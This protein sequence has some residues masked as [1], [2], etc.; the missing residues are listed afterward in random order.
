[1]ARAR[2]ARA[3]YACTVYSYEPSLAPPLP[4]LVDCQK[5]LAALGAKY[6]AAL[7]VGEPLSPRGGRA[8]AELEALQPDVPRR[9]RLVGPHAAS[10]AAARL[11]LRE[12]AAARHVARRRTH[13]ADAAAR[14]RRTSPTVERHVLTRI[15]SALQ[16]M[17]SPEQAR[18]ACCQFLLGCRGCTPARS[19]GASRRASRASSVSSP[20]GSPTR[21]TCCSRRAP[22]S[23]STHPPYAPPSRAPP[24]AA[25]P[26]QPRQA[27]HAAERVAH[28]SGA[29]RAHEADEP[30]AAA[31]S[32]G[33]GGGG[34]RG[35]GPVRAAEE[36]ARSSCS[37]SSSS[38]SSAATYRCSTRRV[39]HRLLRRLLQSATGSIRTACRHMFRQLLLFSFAHRAHDQPLT[40][41]QL[42]LLDTMREEVETPLAHGAPRAHRGLTPT[43][44]SPDAG[45]EGVTDDAPR[46][47]RSLTSLLST[48]HSL[49]SSEAVCA[50][51]G[52]RWTPLL[53]Q[54]LRDGST[55]V[56]ASVLRLLQ[57]TLP[58][59]RPHEATC[60]AA[61][62]A[63]FPSLQRRLPPSSAPL[64]FSRQARL[65]QPKR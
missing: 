15:A 57:V 9:R 55:R 64:A 33:G 14:P 38:A 42:G 47:H 44:P 62:L 12:E 2:R 32:G 17:Q 10:R 53:L 30:H 39:S 7:L 21:S 46:G 41:F 58:A 6:A 34:G 16:S 51:L 63:L 19:G 25:T 13:D 27:P 23:P 29:P 26:D 49:S 56:A 52:D 1:M 59:R 20:H 3:G 61:V 24:E 36:M 37:T 8:L 65:R 11:A 22:R 45:G 35:G 60:D 50:H 40:A 4:L 31:P 54:L 5:S 48:L 28:D 43:P 18:T